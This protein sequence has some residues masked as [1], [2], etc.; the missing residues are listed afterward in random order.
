MCKIVKQHTFNLKTKT[1]FKR[2]L[3]PHIPGFL[4]VSPRSIA[5][6]SPPSP[7]PLHQQAQNPAISGRP[8][9][10]RPV[11]GIFSQTQLPISTG[12]FSTDPFASFLGPPNKPSSKPVR[13]VFLPELLVITGIKYE[14]LLIC[15]LS[16]CLSTL[17][18]TT[19]Q[20]V[21]QS[22]LTSS[23]NDA[24]EHYINYLFFLD[25]SSS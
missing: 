3:V 15:D 2:E 17:A 5:V 22:L 10:P 25:F 21:Y 9:F 12:T 1:V 24:G 6:A 8:S 4:P 20:F 7:P 23:L 16:I 11:L 13:E 14:H 19:P 18:V